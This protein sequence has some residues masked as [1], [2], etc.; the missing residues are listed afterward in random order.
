MTTAMFRCV[1]G[2]RTP[3]EVAIEHDAARAAVARCMESLGDVGRGMLAYMALHRPAQR[4]LTWEKTARLLDELLGHYDAG[5]IE[6]DRV[7]HA[8]T[9]ALWIEAL[10]A[11]RDQAATLTLPLE[12]HAYLLTILAVKASKAHATAEREAMAIKRGE[13][14]IGYS[15]AHAPVS[16]VG[17]DSRPTVDT[18][19]VRGEPVEPP[20]TEARI[21]M[22]DHVRASLSKF[23]QRAPI[24]QTFTQPFGSAKESTDE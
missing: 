11:V 2:L 3:L 5:Y 1:C 23:G 15:A 18:P 4:T 8:L 22:P 17:K 24:A 6:R 7:R 13:T 12:G 14:P 21:P 10:A 16:T 19:A 9:P 20:A